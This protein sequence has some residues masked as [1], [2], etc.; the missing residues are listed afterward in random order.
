MDIKI[1]SIVGRDANVTFT[2]K[3]GSTL[4]EN[5]SLNPYHVNSDVP[6]ETLKKIDPVDD[7]EAFLLQY[8]TAYEKGKE[9]ENKDLSSLVGKTIT[10]E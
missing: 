2:F 7:V 3:D 1:N 6:G 8:A 9:E 10:Q 4:T 5:I